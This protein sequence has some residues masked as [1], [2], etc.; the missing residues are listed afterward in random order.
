MAYTNAQA[1]YV[2]YIGVKSETQ[3][4]A[5]YDFLP[6]FSLFPFSQ[7]D[8]NGNETVNG[9]LVPVN[10]PDGSP[11]HPGVNYVI[12]LAI[13]PVSVQNVTV[14]NN[15]QSQNFGDLVGVLQHSGKNVVLNNHNSPPPTIFPDIYDFVYDQSP[16]PLVGSQPPDGPAA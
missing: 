3:V 7:Q 4:A 9:L 2:Y 11:A 1:D 8:A 14:T 13:Q 15:F 16:Q 12:A 10:I 5:E 6:V